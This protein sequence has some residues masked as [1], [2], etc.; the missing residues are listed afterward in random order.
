VPEELPTFCFPDDAFMSNEPLPPK[1]FDIVLTDMTGTLRYGSCLQY[2][3]EKDPIDVLSMISGIQRGNKTANL[4]PWISLKDIQQHKAQS[5]FFIPK[6]VCMLSSKPL[7]Q[8]FRDSLTVLYRLSIS[9][10]PVSVE[11][12]VLNMLE[13]V[14]IPTVTNTITAF[15]LVDKIGLLSAL[16]PTAPPLHPSE[17]DFTL[18]FQCLSSENILKVYGF[19]LTE[20][21]VVLC[22]QNVSL[23]TPVAETFRALLFPF[24]SQVVYIPVLP[25][26]RTPDSMV[27][28]GVNLTFYS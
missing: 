21:K 14:P 5:K 2:F 3:E 9:T 22:S 10:V 28:S 12:F 19:L 18:L 15:E 4:P 6:C 13:Q 8:A 16:P 24:E 7:F 11:A 25:L 23:L 17:V 20:R 1:T 27:P 26:V